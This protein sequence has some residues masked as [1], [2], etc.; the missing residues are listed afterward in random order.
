MERKNLT[1][2]Q[3]K[4]AAACETA[5]EIMAFTQ[6]EGIELSD[7]DVELIS[8]GGWLGH[9]CPQCGSYDIDLTIDGLIC[10]KCG[11]GKVAK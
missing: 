3:I 9:Q 7:E 1:E 8:G 10:D 2:E 11:Y 4:Q 5:E 6:N